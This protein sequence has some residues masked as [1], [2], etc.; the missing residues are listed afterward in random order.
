[1]TTDER[2]A[3]LEAEVAELKAPKQELTVQRLNIVDEDGALWAVLS[4]DEDGTRLA[5]YGDDNK[6]RV[7]LSSSQQCQSI[8]F[9]NE[10]GDPLA[11]VGT[12]MG[13]PTLEFY[14]ETK[15]VRLRAQVTAKGSGIGL[16][17][18]NGCLRAEMVTD[19]TIPRLVL[20][21][22]DH[23]ERASLA[24]RED[25]T[26][27]RLS[28]KSSHL[29]A[30]LA[31][32]NDGVAAMTLH[33]SND[34]T[35]ICLASLEDGPQV[36]LYNVVGKQFWATPPETDKPN[37]VPH[38]PPQLP[39]P[40]ASDDDI[41]P[42]KPCP[43]SAS[44]N[45][46]PL[47]PEAEHDQ[48]EKLRSVDTW[49]MQYQARHPNTCIADTLD[50]CIRELGLRVQKNA[51]DPPGLI[52]WRT[53][54]AIIESS[55]ALKRATGE[56]AGYLSWIP[57]VVEQWDSET[58]N[59]EFLF[60]KS[61]IEKYITHSKLFSSDTG[62]QPQTPS[63]NDVAD[64][65]APDARSKPRL[66]PIVEPKLQS[67]EN[68]VAGGPSSAPDLDCQPE[69]LAESEL[70]AAGA[71]EIVADLIERGEVPE[72]EAVI[73]A[74]SRVADNHRAQAEQT[75]EETERL[76]EQRLRDQLRTLRSIVYQRRR[77]DA[78]ETGVQPPVS[79]RSHIIE[80]PSSDISAS[81][82]L[83]KPTLPTDE[84]YRAEW[85]ITAADSKRHAELLALRKFSEMMF[86]EA[87]K[88]TADRIER[89]EI[90][91]IEALLAGAAET[92]RKRAADIV[93]VA[94][95]D[96]SKML[97]RMLVELHLPA[98]TAGQIAIKA[99]GVIQ[100]KTRKHGEAHLAQLIDQG[101]VSNDARGQ[102]IVRDMLDCV[103]MGI[104]HGDEQWKQDAR[105]V[106]AKKYKLTSRWKLGRG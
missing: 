84:Q 50:A 48:R 34:R 14:D 19:D 7:I 3:R 11:I 17:D 43:I 45:S 21:D 49:L 100:E 67:E 29:R 22:G 82:P 101:K 102:A 54:K 63:G 25:E 64:R 86:S 2:I 62:G 8:G 96:R 12:F 66:P 85:P 57:T 26:S 93:R 104:I 60:S 97:D 58:T 47:S 61:Y 35:R 18:S 91:E 32:F 39:D 20:R 88:D 41:T 71:R 94:Y 55:S 33:D 31:S 46:Y 51:D 16:C 68:P 1:M 9:T 28:D 78:P 98:R 4:A 65:P 37:P 74:A 95:E 10:K 77:I 59:R 80:A 40:A 24:A 15:K 38:G 79:S 69:I 13:R 23:T 89:G 42:H 52:E 87:I 30:E 56:V 81:T 70:A 75:H 6:A 106:F 83:S 76:R 36:R 92:G 44:V 5:M 105:A 90:P 72:I 103:S 99:Q 73:Q 53:K 27:L